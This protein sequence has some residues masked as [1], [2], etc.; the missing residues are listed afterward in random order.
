MVDKEKIAKYIQELEIYL[1]QIKELQELNKE[2]FL[3]DWRNYDLVDRKLHLILET[4]LSIG[5]MIISEFRLK[6]PDTY[7]DI[8][9]ILSENKIVSKDACDKL[10]DLAKFRNVLVHEYLHLDHERIYEHLHEDP[11]IIE[12]FLKSIKEFIEKD[13]NQQE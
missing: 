7:S 9:K 2:D 8:P 1:E 10:A 5:E 12:G 13:V 3:N 4:Y 11:S 6:K